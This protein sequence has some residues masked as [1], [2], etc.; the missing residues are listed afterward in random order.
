MKIGSLVERIPEIS[1]IW[2]FGNQKVCIE[3][4]KG[5]IPKNTPLIISAWQFCNKSSSDLFEFMIEGYEKIFI[6]NQ[7]SD[8][9]YSPKLFIELQ[10]PMDMYFIEEMQLTEPR[11]KELK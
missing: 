9:W 8:V 6:N 1:L 4:Y 7:W 10:P 2:Y 3:G 11:V 5:T